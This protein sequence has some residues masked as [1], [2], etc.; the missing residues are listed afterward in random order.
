[1]PLDVLCFVF[2]PECIALIGGV[3]IY[4]RWQSVGSD[5]DTAWLGAIST[6]QSQGIYRDCTYPL[7]YMQ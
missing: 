3:A 6:R 4:N 7:F 1:M 2:L 5:E